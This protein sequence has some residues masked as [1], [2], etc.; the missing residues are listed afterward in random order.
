VNETDSKIH[1]NISSP[2]SES[3][4]IKETT[5][6][7]VTDEVL[8]TEVKQFFDKGLTVVNA[9][10]NSG[11]EIPMMYGINFTDFSFAINQGYT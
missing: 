10:L 6:D 11:V 5:L 9:I 8:R 3:V 2:L 4:T 1:G 7:N